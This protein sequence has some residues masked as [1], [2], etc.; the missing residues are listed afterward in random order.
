MLE[1]LLCGK[2]VQP[3]SASALNQCHSALKG[4]HVSDWNG[5]GFWQPALRVAKNCRESLGQA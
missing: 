3:R 1:T 4:L 2:G 5:K